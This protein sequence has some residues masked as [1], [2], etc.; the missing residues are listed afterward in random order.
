MISN[1]QKLDTIDGATLM[2][3]PLRCLEDSQLRIQNRLLQI[4]EDTPAIVHFC[5]EA[6]LLGCGLREQLENFLAEHPDTVLVIIDTLQ[7]VRNARYDNTYAASSRISYHSLRPTGQSSFIPSL[8]LFQ[9]D[10]LRWALAGF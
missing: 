7:I 4:T 5:T 9:P 10:P 2:A 3:Q 6:A 1:Q 8:L